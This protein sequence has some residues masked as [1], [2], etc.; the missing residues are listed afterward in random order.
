M[1]S[2]VC[3]HEVLNVSEFYIKNYFV[4][5]KKIV[6]GLNLKKNIK[7]TSYLKHLIYDAVNHHYHYVVIFTKRA[8]CREQFG[9]KQGRLVVKID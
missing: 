5:L 9:M 6:D 8:R 3:G 7:T 2:L 4:V 1:D